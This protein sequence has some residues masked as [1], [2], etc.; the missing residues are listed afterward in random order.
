MFKRS[1]LDRKP[2]YKSIFL[3]GVKLCNTFTDKTIRL[4]NS[5]QI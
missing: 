5:E 3:R 4:D 1:D 2:I